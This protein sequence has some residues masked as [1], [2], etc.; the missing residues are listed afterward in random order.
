M[1]KILFRI[2]G[3]LTLMPSVLLALPYPV[4]A[5]VIAEECGPMPYLVGQAGPWDYRKER[6]QAQHRVFLAGMVANIEKNHFPPNTELLIRPLQRTFI[7]DIRYTLDRLP[8]HHRALA[9]LVQL[10]ERFNS[11]NPEGS[12]RSIYCFFVRATRFAP[13]DTVVRGLFAE[14]LSRQARPAEAVE[15]L[16]WMEKHANNSPMTHYNLGLL[17][18]ELKHY[19][20][21]L[22]HAHRAL[23]L[24]HPNIDPLKQLLI[25][26]GHWSD[27]AGSFISGAKPTAR[28]AAPEAPSSASK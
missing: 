4:Q 18:N 10:G 25:T 12:D 19:D 3:A 23:D 15:Q 21:A 8:N 22:T 14:Y 11:A 1:T 5:Q 16:R 13:D 9:T 24:G 6:W 27:P 28:S 26:S 2:L 7:D 20:D 17:Y